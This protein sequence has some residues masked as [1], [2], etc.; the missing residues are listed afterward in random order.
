MPRVTA[1]SAS[2]GASSV[3]Q[4]AHF[5]FLGIAGL[6]LA[7]EISISLSLEMARI[8]LHRWPA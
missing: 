6:S 3:V 5:A 1:M 7:R 8:R 4:E 2:V